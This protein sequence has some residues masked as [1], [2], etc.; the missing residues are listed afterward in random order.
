M[1]LATKSAYLFAKNSVSGQMTDRYMSM[2]DN[3]YNL[4]SEYPETRYL[5]EVKS[6]YDRVQVIIKDRYD[7]TVERQAEFE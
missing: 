7:E 5:S 4:I 6:M 3:Y 2:M 1:Y